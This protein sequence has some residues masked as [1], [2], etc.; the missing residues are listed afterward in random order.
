MVWHAGF[1]GPHDTL[2]CFLMM[3]LF[4]CYEA[5]CYCLVTLVAED[6]CMKECMYTTS[7]HI[8]LLRLFLE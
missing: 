7:K 2:P 5:C 4:W 1:L 6:G 3:R 8:S